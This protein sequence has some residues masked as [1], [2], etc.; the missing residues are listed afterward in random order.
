MKSTEFALK[1][2]AKSTKKKQKAL[3]LWTRALSQDKEKHRFPYGNALCCTLWRREGAWEGGWE[4]GTHLRAFCLCNCMCVNFQSISTRLVHFSAGFSGFLL[5]QTFQPYYA[6]AGNCWKRTTTVQWNFGRGDLPLLLMRS[7]HLVK[8]VGQWVYFT[9]F[10]KKINTLSELSS[11]KK[12]KITFCPSNHQSQ[13]F[14]FLC[15]LS[16]REVSLLFSFNRP[17]PVYFALQ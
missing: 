11:L 12:K 7:P 14:D 10:K 16:W 15:F 17:V 3:W 2:N 5:R 9:T 1:T 4:G 6:L 8:I 13:N